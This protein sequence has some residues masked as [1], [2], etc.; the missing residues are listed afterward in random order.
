MESLALV[1]PLEDEAVV[2]AQLVY[3]QLF[4]ARNS[5]GGTSDERAD[6]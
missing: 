6:T 3:F 2:A 5:L 1:S 4:V